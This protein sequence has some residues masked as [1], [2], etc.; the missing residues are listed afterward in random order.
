M[1]ELYDIYCL[2]PERTA[3]AIQRFLELLA[4]MR[5]ERAVDYP[6]PEFADSPHTI[7]T[8]AYELISHCVDHAT[9][10]HSIYWRSKQDGDPYSAMAFF[11]ADKGLILGIS[12]H[13]NAPFWL[14]RL[15]AASAG[16]ASFITIEEP[17]PDNV[18]AFLELART[19]QY[20]F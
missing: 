13:E 3:L 14:T 20:P 1:A 4:P 11:T 16:I 5:D 12:V 9:E 19:R 10:A 15:T 2:A 7:F 6:V 18:P 8:T 17:P